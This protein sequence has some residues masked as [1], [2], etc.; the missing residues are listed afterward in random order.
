M[1]LA[2]PKKQPMTQDDKFNVPQA[3]KQP[4][5]NNQ[6]THAHEGNTSNTGNAKDNP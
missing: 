5:L 4:M 2:A 1:T 3:I 6:P